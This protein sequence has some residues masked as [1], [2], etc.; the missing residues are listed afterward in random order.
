MMEGTVLV[1][2]MMTGQV[3]VPMPNTATCHQAVAQAKSEFNTDTVS[4]EIHGQH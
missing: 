1:I 3:L 2:W 4:C